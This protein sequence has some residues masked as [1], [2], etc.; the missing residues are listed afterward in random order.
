MPSAV[1]A[2]APGATPQTLGVS[3]FLACCGFSVPCMPWGLFRG[4]VG[5]CFLPACRGGGGARVPGP[6]SPHGRGGF[7]LPPAAV[8]AP[9]VL[10]AG[11]DTGE[12]GVPR[13]CDL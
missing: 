1:S 10:K 11:A 8:P 3:N 6:P 12:L 2:L 13:L 5:A 7:P 9:G 4:D